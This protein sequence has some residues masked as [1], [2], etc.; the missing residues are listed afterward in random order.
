MHIYASMHAHASVHLGVGW[1][2]WHD[3]LMV[4]Y[5]HSNLLRLIRDGGGGGAG[6]V[7]KMGTYV[8]PLK[9]QDVTTKT[10]KR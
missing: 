4:L 7:G 5:V 10:M 6:A 8:L 3:R 1:N 2:G 9:Q